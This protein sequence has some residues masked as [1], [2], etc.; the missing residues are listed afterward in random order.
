MPRGRNSRARADL[1]LYHAEHGS[2]QQSIL[3]TVS[4]NNIALMVFTVMQLLVEFGW[5]CGAE[6]WRLQAPVGNAIGYYSVEFA[7]LEVPTGSDL[8]LT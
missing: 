6:W 2:V 7:C 4:H 5:V 8:I 3:V 1:S